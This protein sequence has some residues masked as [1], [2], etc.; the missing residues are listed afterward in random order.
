MIFNSESKEL[1]LQWKRLES[2]RRS[3]N[4]LRFIAPPWASVSPYLLI[5]SQRTV[6]LYNI[7]H[8]L[9]LYLQMLRISLLEG[10]SGEAR[11]LKCLILVL[12]DPVL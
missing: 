6:P 5:T 2:S 7:C 8:C 12:V 11:A 1:L 4:Y 9:G 3:V 10:G